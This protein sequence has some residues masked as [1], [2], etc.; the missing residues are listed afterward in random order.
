MQIN[1]KELCFEDIEELVTFL[2]GERWD[3]HST[4]SL[5]KEKILKNYEEGYF[6][7]D[8]K[9][10]FWMLDDAKKIGVIRLFD[11]G[12]DMLDDETPLFD[13]KIIKDYRGKGIGKISV[14]WLV[15]F[16]FT[17][18]KNKN[19]FEATTRADNISMRRVLEKC[20]FVKEAHY[21][22]AW[23]DENKNLYDCAGYSILRSDWEN[24]TST[25][26]QWDK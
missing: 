24:K 1:F 18:Y 4:P 17:N 14:D 21:R 22:K 20:G 3:Y 7:K 16:V 25:P 23:P 6:T 8:G 9:R 15:N 5:T 2:S 19:R 12:D 13:I 10:T 26:V 11:L